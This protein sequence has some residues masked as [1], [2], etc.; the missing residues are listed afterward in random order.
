MRLVLGAAFALILA[1]TG[2]AQPRVIV[3]LPPPIAI[4][5]LPAAS[6]SVSFVRAAADLRPGTIWAEHQVGYF[7]AAREPTSPWNASANIIG[8]DSG[9]ERTFRDELSAVGF[10]LAGDPTNLF[11]TDK[12]ASDLQVGALIKNLAVR[13]CDA[14]EFNGH[15][16]KGAA[17]MDVEWQVYSVVLAKVVARITTHGG[18]EI[19]KF[20]NKENVGHLIGGAFTDNVRRLAMTDDF[21]KLVGESPTT[22]LRPPVTSELFIN[23][24]RSTKAISLSE[25]SK[26]VVSIFA[27]DGWGSGV[28]ISADGYI[29]TNHHVAG[30]SGR[31]RVRWPDGSDS[32]G[33]VMRGDPRRDVALIK[34]IAKAS[35]LAIRHAPAALGE[36]VFAIGTPL[37]KELAGTLTR[38]VVSSV[39]TRE[40][41]TFIQSDVAV[42]H[43]NSGGPLVDEKGAVIGLTALGLYPEE[44]KSLNLFIPIDDALRALALK[45]EA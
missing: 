24:P 4:K 35:P 29:L 43:G 6:Q 45:P 17:A 34:T 26:A 3:S 36:T 38:G 2:I 25:A 7:C 1:G 14:E 15:L 21:R 12:K 28:L 18:Y 16:T 44:S 11:E 39:R 19:P 30:S 20:S 31:V 8:A 23:L 42:T 32:V 5:P 37:D 40:G 9:F 10:K 33:E 27:G 22:S 41:L 13:Y